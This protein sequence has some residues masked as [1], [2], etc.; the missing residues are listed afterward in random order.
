M[1]EFVR[2]HPI[3]SYFALTFAISWGGVLAVVAPGP[4]PA[5]PQDAERLFVFVYLA[6]LAGP[7]VAGV[8]LTAAVDGLD[9]LRGLRDRLLMWRVAP[10]WYA[11][12]LVTTPLVML[13]AMVVLSPSPANYSPAFLRGDA[14]GPVQAGSRAA[15]LALGLAVGIGA[16]LFEEVGW[17]GFALPRMIERLGT[18]A[19]GL[20]L[21]IV[22]GAWHFLAVL[23]GSGASIGAVP[24]PL[25]L[26]VALFSFLPPYRVL[27]TRVYERTRSLMVAVLMHAGLTSCMLILGPS[28][29]GG[30]LIAHDLV[31]A[32]VLWALVA[33]GGV[34]LGPKAGRI[35][36]AAR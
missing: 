15:F 23:W 4:I 3:G 32:A 31:V 22:W 21:G 25:F 14:S 13:L 34:A 18:F 19:A 17:T 9:G 24:I 1:R 6:M 8:V 26:A 7:I 30:A 20:S 5:F 35:A 28:V 11:A 33:I 16:G 27:M 36:E 10:R 29:A 2:R 12:A